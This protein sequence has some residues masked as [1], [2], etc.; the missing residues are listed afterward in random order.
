[1]NTLSQ[2]TIPVM[3]EEDYPQLYRA[4]DLA[5]RNAQGLYLK[6]VA[7]GLIL[8]LIGAFVSMI[9]VEDKGA[10]LLTASVALFL[11]TASLLIT[12]ALKYLRSEKTWYGGRAAAESV[13]TRVW[14]YVC[15][16]EPLKREL[17]PAESDRIFLNDLKAIVDQRKFLAGAIA[18]AELE[19]GQIT[20][21]M[22][23][24]RALDVQQRLQAYL[25]Q[26]IQS[27]KAWYQVKASWNKKREVF[28]FWVFISTQLLT[29]L[30]ALARVIWPEFPITFATF[31]AVVSSSVLAWLQLKKHQELSQSYGIA[32]HDLSLLAE[33]ALHVQTESDL[34]NFVSEAE[35]A[36][37]REHTLW[38]ARRDDA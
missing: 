26:R 35:N 21:K 37:S 33:Q 24:I 11:F 10:K 15:C 28:L 29:A 18:E 34:G 31:L 14:R 32:A 36:I 2:E 8:S 22:R 19:G 6:L 38:V 7:G 23:A 25:E 3:S 16:A 4:T 5:S 1:M 30:S 20:P 13:K 9:K 12:I 17:P 27:Q